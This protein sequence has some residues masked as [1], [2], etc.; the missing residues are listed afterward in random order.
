MEKTNKLIIRLKDKSEMKFSGVKSY[1]IIGN[2]KVLVLRKVNGMVS[3]INFDEVQ[4][5]AFEKFFLNEEE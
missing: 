5:V 1:E 2:E 3:H 4:Y